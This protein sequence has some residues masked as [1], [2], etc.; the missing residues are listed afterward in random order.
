[1]V[2]LMEPKQFT[3]VLGS[4]YIF[5]KITLW[6]YIVDRGFG[7]EYRAIYGQAGHFV[8]APDSGDLSQ[9]LLTQ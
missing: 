5:E 3:F 2:N 9:Q 4:P 6:V 1:M 7:T 8:R